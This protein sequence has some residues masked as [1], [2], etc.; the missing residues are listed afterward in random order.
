[1]SFDDIFDQIENII[2]NTKV[3][4]E[5]KLDHTGKCLLWAIRTLEKLHHLGLVTE[6]PFRISKPEWVDEVLKDFKPSQED[7]HEVMMWMKK[8]GYIG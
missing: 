1:M 4:G 5:I 7:I 6:G 3:D 8:E 2:D